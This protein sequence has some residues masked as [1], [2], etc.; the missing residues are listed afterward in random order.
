MDFQRIKLVYLLL[1]PCV[2][3]SMVSPIIQNNSA[4]S[5]NTSSYI[6]QSTS[7]IASNVPTAW[8]NYSFNYRQALNLDNPNSFQIPNKSLIQIEL[9]TQQLIANGKMIFKGVDLRIVW[10]DSENSHYH[11]LEFKNQTAFN[12]TKTVIAFQ[13]ETTIEEENPVQNHYL[14]YGNPHAMTFPQLLEMDSE[15]YDDFSQP[16]GVVEDWTGIEENWYVLEQQY[17]ENPANLD[18]YQNERISYYQN[19]SSQN[20][21]IQLD[22]LS[23]GDDFEVGIIFRGINKNKFL[24]AGL[25]LWNFHTAI[26]KGTSSGIEYVSSNGKPESELLS[27]V[28]YNL[29]IKYQEERIEI[30]LDSIL[31]LNITNTY[32]LESGIVGIFC[33]GE[34]ESLFDNFTIPSNNSYIL[35]YEFGDEETHPPINYGIQISNLDQEIENLQN[36]TIIPAELSAVLQL[37]IQFENQNYSLESTEQEWLWQWFDVIPI[38]IGTSDFTIFVQYID[39][40]WRSYNNQLKLVDSTP[41]PSP[42]LSM[43]IVGQPGNIIEF[44]WEDDYDLGGIHHYLLI[45]STDRNLANTESLLFNI[46]ILNLDGNNSHYSITGLIE[47]QFYFWLYQV[48]EGGNMSPPTMG[49]FIIEDGFVSSIT[50][51]HSTM[52]TST[53]TQLNTTISDNSPDSGAIIENRSQFNYLWGSLIGIVGSTVLIQR[54]KIL[55]QVRKH[56]S[57][58]INKKLDSGKTYL[59]LKNDI[60]KTMHIFSQI[61]NEFFNKVIISRKAPNHLKSKFGISC[62]RILWMNT[63]IIDE[64]QLFLP[65]KPELIFYMTKKVLQI[66]ATTFKDQ[67]LSVHPNDKINLVLF[68]GL[69]YLMNYHPFSTVCKL[70][71]SLSDQATINNG[72]LMIIIDPHI[73]NPK[74]LAIL[75]K[76]AEVWK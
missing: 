5:I 13:I 21:Q 72:I 56:Q 8:W 29:A 54:K 65:P 34:S 53:E 36:I 41:P 4:Q 43:N 22:I 44:D 23:R 59:F 57:A 31:Q 58:D 25:G 40:S 66:R 73:I 14:Y 28:W 12:T 37:K 52:T 27:N 76:I 32:I 62:E 1:A 49:S 68:E 46:T 11:N 18:T 2:L 19:Y 30:F 3:L 9:N 10:F 6:P 39:F 48:D 33:N 38:K 26:G 70:L 15:V 7:P 55:S 51:S 61:S 69:E 24:I 50:D 35:S 63:S 42:E 47:G 75:T 67:Q 16:D 71:E 60:S 74:E 17:H 20:G 64:T 45:I